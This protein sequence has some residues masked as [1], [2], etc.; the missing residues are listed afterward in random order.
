MLNPLLDL[1]KTRTINTRKMASLAYS[2]KAMFSG[3]DLEDSQHR[4]FCLALGVFTFYCVYL[5]IQYISHSAQR[6]F[7]NS[8]PW[9]GVAGK[10][11]FS[12]TRAGIEAIRHTRE[13]VENGYQQVSFNEPLGSSI[14]GSN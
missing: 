13:I 12:R 10:L 14:V 2:A 3:I 4:T 9:V 11:L 6:K 7:W 5:V 1:N 8:Q